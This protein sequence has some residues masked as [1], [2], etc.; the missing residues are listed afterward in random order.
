LA[1][2]VKHILV[3]KGQFPSDTFEGWEI[4]TKGQGYYYSNAT[5]AA[6]QRMLA[7][8]D[9]VG[10]EMGELKDSIRLSQRFFIDI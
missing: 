4:D 1:E 3:I 10:S 8:A 2:G 9:I 7:I 5:I 6:V